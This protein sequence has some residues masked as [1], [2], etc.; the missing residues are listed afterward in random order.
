MIKTGAAVLISKWR[1]VM[2]IP[3][4][5][6]EIFMHSGGQ[7]CL[8]KISS[9]THQNLGQSVSTPKKLFQATNQWKGIS[10]SFEIYAPAAVFLEV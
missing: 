10:K 2:F 4:S 1:L 5:I 8:H 3:G 9:A 6:L 7:G